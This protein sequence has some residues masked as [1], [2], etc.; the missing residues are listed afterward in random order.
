[1]LP[2]M[3]ALSQQIQCGVEIHEIA[4]IIHAMAADKSFFHG[5]SLFTW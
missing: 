5:K 1:M 4:E 3:A 2:Q